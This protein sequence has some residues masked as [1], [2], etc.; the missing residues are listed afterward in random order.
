MNT[1][2]HY[3][4]YGKCFVI[5]IRKI[6]G[7]IMLGVVEGW[8]ARMSTC[9]TVVVATIPIGWAQTTN[10]FKKHLTNTHNVCTSNMNLSEFIVF[11]SF[12]T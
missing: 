11:E 7:N 12:C 4:L 1:Y 2:M 3:W 6:V 9:Q 10:I 5:S 8:I